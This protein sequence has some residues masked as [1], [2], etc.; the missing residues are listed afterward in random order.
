MWE[1]QFDY[2]LCHNDWEEVSKLLD[3]IPNSSLSERNLLIRL[4]A[5]KSASSIGCSVDFTDYGSYVCS[6][7]ELDGVCMEIPNVRI[8]NCS[9]NTMWSSWLTVLT[10]KELAKRFIFL[11]EYWDGTEEIMFLLARS[12]FL[13]GENLMPSRTISLHHSAILDCAT[14]EVLHPDTVQAFHKLVVH[15]CVQYNLPY[16]LDLFLDHH[17]LALD[18]DSMSSLQEATVS[19]TYLILDMI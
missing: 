19:F 10:G 11:K 9:A 18:D 15:H 16:F 17:K 7:D 12:G 5:L 14:V 13:G 4:D 1:S 6:P 3:M 8:L 2:H